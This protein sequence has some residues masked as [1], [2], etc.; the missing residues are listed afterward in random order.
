L[1]IEMINPELLIPYEKNAKL[2]PIEQIEKLAK[3]ISSVGFTQ[4]IVVTHDNVIVVGHGRTRA[5][6]LLCMKK[7]PVHR[8]SADIKPERVRA[9]RLFDNKISETSWSNELLQFEL[10]ELKSFDDFDFSCTGFEIEVEKDFLP[11]LPK[12]IEEPEEKVEII[13]LKVM[14]KSKEEQEELFLELRERGFAV[15]A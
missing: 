7:V 5:A 13:F 4:P 8:L 11:N 1:K 2:H 12:E 9:M 14:C 3:E 6:L 10:A 15:K